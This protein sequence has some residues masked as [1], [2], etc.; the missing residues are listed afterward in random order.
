MK[1][2]LIG[3][4]GSVIS[5]SRT[6]PAYLINNDL[7]LD[8]G[9]GTTQKLQQLGVIDSID[10]ICLTHLHNDHF[11]G[12]VSLIWYY[13]ISGKS[14]QLNI[15][16]PK[17][18]TSTIQ[19]VL[20]L[21]HTPE[22]L[23]QFELNFKELEEMN[24]VHKINNY[25][26]IHAASMEHGFPAYA[27]RIEEKEKSVTYSGDTKFNQNL[28]EL[29]KNTDIFVCEATFPDR[30]KSFAQKHNHC[31]PKD[32]AKIARDSNSKILI[33]V[34]ISPFFE[35]IFSQMKQNAEKI[36]S[37]KVIIGEDLKDFEI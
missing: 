36:F 21:A 35:V 17:N 32:A 28:I 3:T 4:S 26:T 18:T 34:H 29:A 31:T 14:K 12:I 22:D 10:T 8:C 27:Y 2:T 23:G 20:K 25:Y 13:W 24:E 1:L 30:L 5:S 33:L 7:L 15:I 6:Y 9:E 16:G 37:N 19:E 11:M